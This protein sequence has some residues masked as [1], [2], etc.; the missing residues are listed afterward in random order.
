MDRSAMD[1]LRK[2]QL[3]VRVAEYIASC[4]EA[5][6]G[7]HYTSEIESRVNENSGRLEHHATV[8]Q[9]DENGKIGTIGFKG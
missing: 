4:E 9:F 8:T 6:P 2:Q 1:I 7:T 5:M 3:E